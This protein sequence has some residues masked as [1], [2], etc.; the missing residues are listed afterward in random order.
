[1]RR[2]SCVLRESS[3]EFR[4]PFGKL[5]TPPRWIFSGIVMAGANLPKLR[6]IEHIATSSDT[7]RS[8]T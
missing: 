1:M 7:A 2:F 4:F 5:G 8:E 6:N 3:Q